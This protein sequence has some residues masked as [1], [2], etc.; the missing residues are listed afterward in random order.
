[1]GW[2]PLVLV[3]ALT[4]VSGCGGD[5]ETPE[6]GPSTL[7]VEVL[8]R[9]APTAPVLF[10][11][12]VAG[13]KEQAGLPA[14]ADALQPDDPT[15]QALALVNSVGP[16]L[17]VVQFPRSEIAGAIDGGA[18]TAS[19][20]PALFAPEAV[21]AFRTEQ[22]FGEIAEALVERGFERNGALLVANSSDLAPPDFPVVGDGGD[23]VV[24]VA[25]SVEAA[26]RAIERTA[27]PGD[28]A[29]MEEVTGVIRGLETPTPGR[30]CVRL[31]AVGQDLD[32]AT[33]EL[34]YEIEGE[35]EPSRFALAA[36][37]FGL[38]AGAASA[39]DGLLRVPLTFGTD[40]GASVAGAG[41]I[42]A[43]SGDPGFAAHYRC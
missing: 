28:V 5:D 12:D 1:M 10:Y 38:E 41:P 6:P 15:P 42:T 37:V 2:G 31:V 22:P 35:A 20:S 36:D 29:L 26:E 14:S 39:Q 34:L 32:P 17:P 4:L 43:L 11:A 8:A 3:F 19:A 24:V 13:A 30:G 21:S 40:G 27:L 18:I 9:T 23:G 25:G 33:G 7:D 16:A